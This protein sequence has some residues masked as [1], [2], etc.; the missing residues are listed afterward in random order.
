MGEILDT[1]QPKNKEFIQNLLRR[2]RLNDA[3]DNGIENNNGVEINSFRA[4]QLNSQQSKSG[5]QGKKSNASLQDGAQQINR[6]NQKGLLMADKCLTNTKSLPQSGQASMKSSPDSGHRSSKT[7]FVPLFS[8]EGHDRTVALIPGRHICE[9][10]AAKHAL[11]NN[12]Q[13][14]GRIVCEQEGSGPCFFCH[15]LVCSKQEQEIIDR[16]SKK[17]D[18][19]RDFLMRQTPMDATDSA[20]DNTGLVKALQHRDRLLEYDKTSAK[21]THVIDDES[22]YFATDSN[23]WL[24]SGERKALQCKEAELRERRFASRRDRKVTIDFA[25][26]R[27]VEELPSS[28]D[29]YDA[30]QFENGVVAARDGKRG[31]EDVYDPSDFEFDLINPNV[32]VEPPTFIATGRTRLP[33]GNNQ[34]I[35]MDG[36]TLRNLRLQD[37][38]LQVMSDEGLALSM[39][40]PWA[41]LLI[42]GIKRHE[43]RTWYTAHRGILWIAATA[44]KTDPHD[45]ISVENFYKNYYGND[46]RLSFP[47]AYPNGCLLGCVTIT[48]CLAHDDYLEQ[49]PKGESDSPYV[50]LCD[51]P[52][53][54]PVK[55]PIKGK[56]KIYKLD[57]HIHQ[58]AKKNIA[59][60]RRT[61]QSSFS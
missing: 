43:G 50:F 46:P 16:N 8:P 19:L 17:S 5:K 2:C 7:K 15:S 27:V 1:S 24:Q 51:N 57:R 34:N 21:R 53:E 20:A 28:V 12:C 30:A 39:H 60:Q 35:I 52:Q 14:C 54:L 9:C 13:G 29:Q 23:Q 26:R 32:K 6:T 40:Q 49:F 44:K 22:D 59:Q 31:S 41:S 45:V 10:Q 25:G 37:S 61:V 4:V 58:A 47:S 11:V 38:E 3:A 42:A 48:D 55:F 36:S 56:H 18:R 33:T